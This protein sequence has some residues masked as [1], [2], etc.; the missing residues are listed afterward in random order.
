[1]QTSVFKLNLSD[2]LRFTF[3]PG[4]MQTCCFDYKR[5]SPPSVYIPPWFNADTSALTRRQTTAARL[6]STLVQCRHQDENQ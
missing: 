6:H 2:Y 1:M 5:Y 3:H 4:S